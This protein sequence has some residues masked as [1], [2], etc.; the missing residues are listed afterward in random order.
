MEEDDLLGDN[1]RRGMD[2]RHK[3]QRNS[4]AASGEGERQDSRGP[5]HEQHMDRGYELRDRF[6]QRRGGRDAQQHHHQG[7]PKTRDV[8][9]RPREEGGWQDPKRD[10][11]KGKAPRQ[12]GNTK[13]KNSVVCFRCSGEGH[14]Q[15]ECTNDPICY[16]CKQVGHMA[17][18]CGSKNSKSRISMFGFGIPGQ[19][20]YAID[21]PDMKPKATK[22]Q[23]LITVIQG[24]AT[25]SKVDMELKNLIEDEWDFKV[26]RLRNGEFLATFP[27]DLSVEM[28]S[29]FS[30]VDL[31]L[32]GLKVKI[33][34]TSIDATTSSVLQSAWVKIYGIPDF[35]KDEEIVRDLASLAAEPVKVDTASLKGEG[36]VRV[37]VK[38][39]DPA[40]LRGFLE[41]FFNG[42]GYEIK[43]AAEGSQE[44]NQ[45]K[46][47]GGPPGNQK[48]NQD[49]H[50]RNGEGDKSGSRKPENSNKDNRFTG[51]EQNDSQNSLED[52]M[53][54]LIR[55]DSLEE[56]GEP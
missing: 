12:E 17:A 31:A 52:S 48:G 23:G 42:V 24:D 9:G 13:P 11:M 34:R 43:F 25:E 39:R 51:Q 49:K 20:F 26:K 32:F 8:Q 7:D 1:P 38:C 21:V 16:K 47:P 41:V 29:K 50:K 15:L 2:L 55:D 46:G 28:F 22:V 14:H 30:S 6:D 3:L 19:G 37:S 4:V 44:R 27:D 5:R 18:E 53:E 36:P 35:A 40:K 45:G 10:P 33:A 54:D 56:V